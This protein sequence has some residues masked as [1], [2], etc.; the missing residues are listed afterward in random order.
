[1]QEEAA[2]PWRGMSCVR[3]SQNWICGMIAPEM[4]FL[5]PLASFLLF[6]EPFLFLLLLLLCITWSCVPQGCCSLHPGKCS[7][8]GCHRGGRAKP[9]PP[10]HCPSIRPVISSSLL[11]LLHPSCC[12]TPGPSLSPSCAIPATCVTHW[13]CFQYLFKSLCLCRR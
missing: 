1:M 6:H 13:E 9:V 3:K 5:P 8:P 10:P 12:L 4:S 2:L 7:I 11:L